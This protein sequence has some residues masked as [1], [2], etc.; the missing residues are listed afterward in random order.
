MS[1]L[2]WRA[3][4]GRSGPRADQGH[5]PAQHADQLRQ[6]VDV[7]DAEEPAQR[8]ALLVGHPPGGVRVAV[9]A[10]RAQLDDL[11]QLSAAD[12]AD[13]AEQHRTGQ[14]QPDRHRRP[15]RAPAR[16]RPAQ[17]ARPPMSTARLASRGRAAQADRRSGI[18]G[19]P[20]TSSR[21]PA[22]TAMPSS[23]SRG[24]THTSA[25]SWPAGA[26]TPPAASGWSPSRPATMTRLA[27]CRPASPARSATEAQ[28]VARSPS[29]GCSRSSRASCSL[30]GPGSEPA[31]PARSAGHGGAPR[32]APRRRPP[33]TAISA[34]AVTSDQPE[35]L[36]RIGRPGQHQQPGQGRRHRIRPAW[37]ATRR[38]I[39]SRCSPARTARRTHAAA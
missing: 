37:S 30:A 29:S 24:S 36:D 7:G 5:V 21:Q 1:W 39:R 12:D 18:S 11:G 25:P 27:R 4:C 38:Q 17:A 16:S 20:H 35:Q 3:K 23:L 31:R 33:R 2:N 28:L 13:L 19:T 22:G 6:L 32:A 15:P 9:L 34:T 14:P 26:Q 8:A 10:Q